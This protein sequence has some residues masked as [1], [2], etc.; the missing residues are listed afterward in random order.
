MWFQA[1][2]SQISALIW[3]VCKGQKACT[4]EEREKEALREVDGKIERG[5]R[6][7]CRGRLNRE[8]K[9][10]VV[11]WSRKT[12]HV[13]NRSLETRYMLRFQKHWVNWVNSS[14]CKVLVAK[15]MVLTLMLGIHMGEGKI[16][17]QN[18]ML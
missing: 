15:D 12:T 16:Y 8:E 10:V 7:S 5:L 4:L 6:K 3:N 17:L 13:G 2:N 9:S 1:L 14:A 18:M 11:K